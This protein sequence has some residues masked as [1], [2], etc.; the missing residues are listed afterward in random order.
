MTM[1]S[2]KLNRRI[3]IKEEKKIKDIGGGQTTQPLPI[4]DT[5]A[6]INTLTGREFWQ[7]QQMEAEVSHKITIRYRKGIKRSQVVFYNERKFD[8]EYIFNRDE[9]NKFLELYCLERV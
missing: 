4:A 3:S 2:G 6:S 1:N 5:W 7:A 9:A 8:I